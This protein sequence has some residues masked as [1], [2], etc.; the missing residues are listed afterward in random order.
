M[1]AESSWESFVF[2]WGVVCLRKSLCCQ[3]SQ[4]AVDGTI[5]FSIGPLD[6]GS[7]C[8]A[9][10]RFVDEQASGDGT[11]DALAKENKEES[12]FVAFL[13]EL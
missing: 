13:S 2:E 11:K 10:V 5:Y 4:E 7:L 12:G 8:C 3:Q 1:S 6:F 9:G